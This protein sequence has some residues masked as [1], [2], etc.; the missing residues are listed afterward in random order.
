MQEQT[1]LLMKE[2]E[3]KSG[4]TSP[5]PAEAVRSINIAAEESEM[6]SCDMIV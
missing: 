5:V 2:A 6:S 4:A 1:V 3:E